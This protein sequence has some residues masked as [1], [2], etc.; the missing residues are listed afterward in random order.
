MHYVPVKKDL[1]DLLVQI[2]WLR[3][4]DDTAHK[5]AQNAFDF[6]L[7]NLMFEDVYLYFYLVLQQYSALQNLDKKALLSE[8]AKDSHWVKIQ[9]RKE[10]KKIADKTCSKIFVFPPGEK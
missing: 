8:M 9:K 3:R 2:D 10:L 6:A 5:I 1:S 7:N 4:N